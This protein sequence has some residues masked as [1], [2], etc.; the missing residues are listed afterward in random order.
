M[1][2]L[3]QKMIEEM[4][5]RGLAE[6]T[7]QSYVAAVSGLAR[8]YQKSPEQVSEAELR[9]YILELLQDKEVG[10]SSPAPSREL[11]D[12]CRSNPLF[13]ARIDNSQD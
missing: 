11:G 10:Q 1:T 8:Y 7:Q 2:P 13:N 3:R 9:A 5:L 4:Q 6:R 12:R